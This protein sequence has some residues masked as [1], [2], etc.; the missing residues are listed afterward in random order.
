VCDDGMQGMDADEA[1]SYKVKERAGAGGEEWE[2]RVA[3]TALLGELGTGS[4]V[5]QGS[6][7]ADNKCR[8]RPGAVTG[9]W[10]SGDVRQQPHCSASFLHDG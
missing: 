4:R 3:A 5:V 7:V 6:H 9:Q 2:H 10:S 1:G 8:P